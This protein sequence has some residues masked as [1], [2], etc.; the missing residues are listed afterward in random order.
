MTYKNMN[1]MQVKKLQ[2]T[3]GNLV[4]VVLDSELRTKKIELRKLQEE[5]TTLRTGELMSAVKEDRVYRQNRD[6]STELRKLMRKAKSLGEECS[7][8]RRI[9]TI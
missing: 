9:L 8:L 5:I 4:G 6:E 7:S 2:R 3:M 1:E